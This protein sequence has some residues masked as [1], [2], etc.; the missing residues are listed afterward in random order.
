[1]GIYAPILVKSWGKTTS[2]RIFTVYLLQKKYFL[3][4][5]GVFMPL[6]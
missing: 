6:F 2:L 5:L 1:M 4:I 3:G